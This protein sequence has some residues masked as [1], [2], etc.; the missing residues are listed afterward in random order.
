[1]WMQKM[2]VP[3]AVYVVSCSL[4]P[5]Q[6]PREAGMFWVHPLPVYIPY[7]NHTS[8]QGDQK[9]GADFEYPPRVKD[10]GLFIGW[11]CKMRNSA[12]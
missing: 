1:M 5:S 12:S 6:H 10:V 3:S 2:G 11:T 9:G 7:S 8:L 4:C